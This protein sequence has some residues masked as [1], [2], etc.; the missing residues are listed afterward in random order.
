MIRKLAASFLAF[1][2]AQVL[3]L[4]YSI[5]FAMRYVSEWF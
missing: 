4:A 5:V 2:I 3:F 1:I